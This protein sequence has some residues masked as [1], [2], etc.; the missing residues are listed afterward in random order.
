MYN[1]AGRWLRQSDAEVLGR[2]TGPALVVRLCQAIVLPCAVQTR[3]SS[4]LYPFRSP[5]LP[6]TSAFVARSQFVSQGHGS[7]LLQAVYEHAHREGG[8]ELTVE[9]PNPKF[10]LVR[11]IVDLRRCRAHGVLS[12]N[13][14]W[15]GATREML[16]QAR[17]RLLLTE[18]QALRCYEIQ[19]YTE[20]QLVDKDKEA[21]FKS[22]RLQVKRRLSKKYKEELDALL[23]ATEDQ[24]DC[25]LLDKEDLSERRKARLDELFRGLVSEYDILSQRLLSK[26][27]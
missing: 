25:G 23:V 8:I 20:L 5:S 11:D 18:E 26:T 7:A 21:L 10:R 1:V 19:Q 13:P 15:T 14:D 6:P 24:G 17:R 3:E 9:D 2:E 16:L 22:W 27:S 12:P 4:I